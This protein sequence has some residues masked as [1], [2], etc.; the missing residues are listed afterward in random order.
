MTTLMLR[1]S[2]A[3]RRIGEWDTEDFEVFDGARAVG[4]IF[5][6]N[7]HKD[8]FFWGVSFLLT[9]RKSYGYATNLE[10]AKWLFQAEYEKW[11][12]QRIN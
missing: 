2:K 5:R 3:S 11:K 4:R 10:E 7:S 1:R 12:R 9:R 8:V 6:V